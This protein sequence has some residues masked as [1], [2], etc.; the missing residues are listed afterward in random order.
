MYKVFRDNIRKLLFQLLL[1][2]FIYYTSYIL[3]LKHY[4]ILFY[5]TLLIRLDKKA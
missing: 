2:Y 1:F 4:L 5:L 3:F